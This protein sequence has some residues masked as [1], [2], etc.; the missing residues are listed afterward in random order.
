M[1]YNP[2]GQQQGGMDPQAL[3]QLLSMQQGMQRNMGMQRPMNNQPVAPQASNYAGQLASA[4]MTGYKFKQ[5]ANTADGQR[6]Q[7][8]LDT[9]MAQPAAQNGFQKMGGWIGG[10][11]GGGGA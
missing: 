10:L 1:D 6:A 8:I 2:Y 3:S 9:G 7:S 5:D 4:L 11:F